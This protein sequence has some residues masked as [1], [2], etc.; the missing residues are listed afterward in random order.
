M[1]FVSYIEPELLVLIPVLYVIGMVLKNL[2]EVK[3]KFIPIILLA[4]GI[5]IAVLYV[6]ATESLGTGQEVAAA[7][8]TAIC[9]GALVAGATVYTNQL[10]KQSSKSE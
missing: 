2:E 8:F 1:D 3:D 9:Q 5:A 10:I 4:L 7:V 6:L